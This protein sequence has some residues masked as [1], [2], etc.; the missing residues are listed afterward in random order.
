[1]SF[2]QEKKT[3]LTIWMTLLSQAG[4]SLGLA[5]EVANQFPGWGRKFQAAIISCVI[6]NQLIGPVLCKLALKWS[7]EAGLSTGNE[8]EV[9]NEADP[10]AVHVSD[11]NKALIL[12]TTSRS[13]AL[14]I[15][16]LKQRWGVVMLTMD[17][18]EADEL[19]R[20]I[21]EWAEMTRAEEVAFA[22]FHEFEPPAPP[23]KAIEES[24]KAIA[25]NG[26]MTSAALK[27]PFMRGKSIEDLVGL[28]HQ[29][30]MLS[31]GYPQQE[32]D[33]ND[34][35]VEHLVFDIDEDDSDD[36]D[37]DTPDP[38]DI[39][40]HGSA[41]GSNNYNHRKSMLS[42][43]SFADRCNDIFSNIDE[44]GTS[45][46]TI[47][48]SLP[49]DLAALVLLEH[50]Q[51]HLGAQHDKVRYISIMNELRWA[52]AFT[53]LDAIPLHDFVSA[54][55]VDN[56]ATVTPYK[57]DCIIVRGDQMSKAEQMSD[58]FLNLYD[59]PMLTKFCATGSS[60]GDVE[61]KSIEHQGQSMKLFSLLQKKMRQRKTKLTS[62]RMLR[63]I[64]RC[65]G[66]R[67]RVMQYTATQRSTRQHTVTH[68]NTLHAGL[69]RKVSV[70][71]HTCDAIHC[72][73]TQY[74]DTPCNTL[75]HTANIDMLSK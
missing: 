36:P 17:Q 47:V 52:E 41:L 2:Y 59:G 11:L 28:V 29:E 24:F 30:D 32:H 3:N 39:S 35:K 55:Q 75:Q 26:N 21:K 58:S 64:E 40:E 74:I 23:A 45:L 49:D 62:G 44:M 14:A 18:A 73:T 38:D 37:V 69:H 53:M 46:K 33:N 70:R 1:V 51:E 65:V 56:I 12:G 16:L 60:L 57:E 50:I 13:K 63:G 68:C 22:E 72:N 19:E 20:D 6:V 67:T 27:H 8:H 54:I 42:G 31:Q 9:E 71:T 66:D 7:G 43:K 10:N 15:A 5:A 4:F 48:L 61:L 25:V 34:A